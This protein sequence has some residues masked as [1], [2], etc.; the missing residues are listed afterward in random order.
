MFGCNLKEQYIGENESLESGGMGKMIKVEYKDI[1]IKF[2]LSFS[3]KLVDL[4]TNVTDRIKKRTFSIGY[5]DTNGIYHPISSDHDL[6][7]CI[8]ESILKEA[9][10]ITMVVNLAA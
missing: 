7:V 2:P 3:A 5:K 6:K 8:Q 4:K 10:F 9:T 1:K